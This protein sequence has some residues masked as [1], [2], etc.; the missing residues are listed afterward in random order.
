METLIFKIT[1]RKTAIPTYRIDVSFLRENKT[2]CFPK[3]V[4]L[5][6]KDSIKH[7]VRDSGLLAFRVAGKWIAGSYVLVAGTDKANSM[8]KNLKEGK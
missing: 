3:N 4:K 8:L 6:N 2:M 5:S 7:L 1:E